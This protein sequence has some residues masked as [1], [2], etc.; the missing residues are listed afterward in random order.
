MTARRF[1][2]WFLGLLLYTTLG[3][4][5]DATPLPYPPDL[6]PAQLS[7]TLAAPG[8]L[9]LRG[10]PG[11]A[12]PAGL[13]LELRNAARPAAPATVTVAA[14]GSFVGTLAGWLSD[15]LRVTGTTAGDSTVLGYLAS[16]G[17][18][19]VRSVPAPADADGDGWAASLD[20]D[21]AARYSFPGA[22]ELCDGRDNDCNGLADEPPACLPCASD[23]DCLNGRFCDG[24][25]VCAA[26][27]CAPAAA[28]L[29]DDGDPGTVDGCDP[30]ADACTHQPAP[31]PDCGNGLVEAGESCD[32]GNTVAGDGCDPGCGGCVPAAELCNGLDDDCDGTIDDGLACSTSCA[33]D[34]D[35]DDGL[36]CTSAASC[37]AGACIVLP[38][39]VCDDSD[40][41]TTDVCD[42]TSDTCSHPICGP[43]LCNGF[44]DDCDGLVD[45]DFD[46]TGDPL[47]CGAC[48]TACAA[49]ESCIDGICSV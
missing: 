28:V 38:D 26:G 14:D 32:D 48:G 8:S 41:A 34:A 31:L 33:V 1:R 18:P 6:Q 27:V 16:D 9:E 25:E 45:E 7:L 22:R 36:F 24:A 5:C 47:N 40:P 37:V 20:C 23:A 15:T 44:D 35:C 30:F 4:A 12:A 11:A 13:V 49:G 10:A 46:F 29:C 43:E 2:R 3:T 19:G 21:D 39:I 17:S 42:E